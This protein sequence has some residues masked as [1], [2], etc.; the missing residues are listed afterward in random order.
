MGND[1]LSEAVEIVERWRAL[2]ARPLA[3]TNAGL[4]YYVR[5]ADAEPDVTQRLK[6]FATIVD[7]LQRHPTMSLST[8]EDVG[9]VRAILP[10]QAQVDTVVASI[11]HQPRWNIRRVRE[12]VSGRDPGPKDDGYRASSASDFAIEV[13]P[14]HELRNTAPFTHV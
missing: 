9:G 6:R 13:G 1:A 8:M 7:K 14:C 10:T 12:Y 2:H 3:K 11:R 5:R 4:R